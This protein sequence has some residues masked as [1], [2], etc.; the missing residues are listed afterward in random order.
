MQFKNKKSYH[1]LFNIFHCGHVN[2]SRHDAK[3][4]KL[5]QM[6]SSVFKQFKHQIQGRQYNTIQYNTLKFITLLLC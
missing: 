1:L 3:M 2:I 4:L 6:S 5:L